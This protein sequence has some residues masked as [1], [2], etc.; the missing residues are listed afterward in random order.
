MGSLRCLSPS[1]VETA[2]GRG[3]GAVAAP[4]AR[5]MG[6]APTG[7]RGR[8]RSFG[9][10]MIRRGETPCNARPLL[11]PPPAELDEKAAFRMSTSGRQ[12]SRRGLHR[13]NGATSRRLEGVRVFWG[14]GPP[15]QPRLQLSP[16]P[17]PS[18]AAHASGP[19]EVRRT[20]GSPYDCPRWLRAR[21][22]TVAQSQGWPSPTTGGVTG[23]AGSTVWQR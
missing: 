12:G 7:A 10:G 11:V 6:R 21:A 1:A 5:P 17:A 20:A 3:A 9:G 22:C 16:V 8:N 14:C 13:P 2:S 19:E 23:R 18:L 15:K 4:R